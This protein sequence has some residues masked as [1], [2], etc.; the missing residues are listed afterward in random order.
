[1]SGLLR[2]LCWLEVSLACFTITDV[3]V[4][5]GDGMSQQPVMTGLR[6]GGDLYN[7]PHQGCN[8]I[9]C[10]LGTN[11]QPEPMRLA[12]SIQGGE[13][14]GLKIQIQNTTY[15]GVVGYGFRYGNNPQF[16]IGSYGFL[17]S[18][19]LP[20]AKDTDQTS[21]PNTF[22]LSPSFTAN[23]TLQVYFNTTQP[24]FENASDSFFYQCL[25]LKL[26]GKGPLPNWAP[27]D[28]GPQQ[29]AQYQRDPTGKG[30]C[31]NNDPACYPYVRQ[32]H[33]LDWL[34][35]LIALAVLVCLVAMC[36]VYFCVKKK[37]PKKAATPPPEPPP[38]H[39]V[40]AAPVVQQK[41]ATPSTS[42]HS[43]YAHFA[44]SDANDPPSKK[45]SGSTDR[46]TGSQG[47]HF[48]FHYEEPEAEGGA[49][50]KADAHDRP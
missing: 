16:L 45:D 11:T 9:P 36:V 22:T 6:D 14:I 4:V 26:T 20:V 3:W 47:R 49:Q 41:E 28:F 12:V 2:A 23:A 39:E 19:P 7:P 38:P 48:H 21:I 43:A 42:K 30:A 33:D 27:D 50:D 37:P 17:L 15:S 29:A 18:E 8:R 25:D 10:G 44:F 5:S 24:G 13:K 40:E 34:W 32:P 1:M 46:N 31:G 35:I